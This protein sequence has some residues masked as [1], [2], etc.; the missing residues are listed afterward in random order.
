MSVRVNAAAATHRAD[1][2]TSREKPGSLRCTTL[3]DEQHKAEY[4]PEGHCREARGQKVRCF[5]PGRPSSS[6]KTGLVK[7]VRHISEPTRSPIQAV[8]AIRASDPLNHNGFP[9][10][11]A[12]RFGSRLAQI[13]C[14]ALSLVKAWPQAV[15]QRKAVLIAASDAS[16][17]SGEDIRGLAGCGKTRNLPRQHPSRQPFGLPQGEVN[18]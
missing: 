11:V 1:A 8:V 14:V 12:G 6:R 9:V 18:N 3:D 17:I 10:R 2:A 5:D 4:V 16:R 13:M 7:A 15:A